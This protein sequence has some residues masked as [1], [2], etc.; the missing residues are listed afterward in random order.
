[1]PAGVIYEG[2]FAE[3]VGGGVSQ[4]AT[5]MFN[6]SFFAGLDLVAFQAHSIYIDRYPYGREA[7]VNWPGIDLKVRNPTDYP[8]LIWTEYTRDSITVKLF[9]TAVVPRR[10]DRP[11]HRGGRRVH[12]R[13]YRADPHVGRW[14]GRDRLCR[15]HIPAARRGRM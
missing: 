11:N 1:M 15:G 8:V 12:A 10:P 7:T 4:F 6:A 3:D 2:V 13:A 14:A 5:T 9:G